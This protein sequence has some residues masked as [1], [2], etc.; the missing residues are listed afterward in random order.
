[1]H[2]V[3]MA[4]LVAA[5]FACPAAA[6]W[7]V[8]RGD[9]LMSGSGAAKL[10]DQL[11]VKWEFDPKTKGGGIEGAPAIVGGV[12]FVASLDKHL[13][14]LDLATG[15]EKWKAKLGAMKA[16]P[17]VRDGRVYV[18][19]LDGRFHCVSAAD[20]K[21]LWKFE[22]DGEITAGAN[23]HGANVLFGCHD[24]HLYCLNADGKKVWTAKVE[25][26]IAAAAAVVGN[27]TFA[28]GCSDGVLRAFDA[29]TGNPLGALELGGETVTTAAIAGDRVYQSMISNSVVSGNVKDLK[30]LWAFTPPARQQPFYSSAAVSDGV[31]VAG[32]RDKRLYALEADTGKQLW[33][34]AAAGQIDASPVIVSG[35]VYV[36]SCDDD[37]FFYTLD[38]KTGKELHKLKLDA[39][40]SGS[41]AVGPD[42]LLVGTDRGTVFCLGKK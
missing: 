15:N 41:A 40:V 33:S 28:T 34:F 12:A 36:G 27:T 6:D 3:V 38:L 4:A 5:L 18:G 16:S 8:F 2:R 21:P 17:A 42:C 22:T 32:S 13:Y 20:G 39:A 26:P 30:K 10:P 25:G 37:G 35:R 19:D 11:G 1:M 24:S 23:F 29:K 7:P 9:G 14:A 31:V